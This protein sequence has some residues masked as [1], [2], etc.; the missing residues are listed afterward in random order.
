[1]ISS[2]PQT[3]LRG[4]SVIFDFSREETG[5]SWTEASEQSRAP[6]LNRRGLTGTDWEWVGG[7]GVGVA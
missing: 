1:M 2:D 6:T 4:A 3:A 7:G 5:A